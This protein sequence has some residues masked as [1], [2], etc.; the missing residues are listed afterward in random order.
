MNLKVSTLMTGENGNNRLFAD[1]QS[2]PIE[3]W[4]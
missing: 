1:F 3:L 2:S 4:A